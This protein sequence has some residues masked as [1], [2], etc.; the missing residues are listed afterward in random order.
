MTPA[1]HAKVWK[2]AAEELGRAMVEA[3]NK[4]NVSAVKS[5]FSSYSLADAVATAYESSS[6][7]KPTK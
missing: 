5:Y 4:N 1:E 6:T 2:K 3:K 7:E